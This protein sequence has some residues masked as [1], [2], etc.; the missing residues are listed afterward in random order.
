MEMKNLNPNIKT[1]PPRTEKSPCMYREKS[2]KT[3]EQTTK[4]TKPH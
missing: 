1:K 4:A 2:K 3:K